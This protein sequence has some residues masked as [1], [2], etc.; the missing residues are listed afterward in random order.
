[1]LSDE[2]AAQDSYDGEQV[3]L[4]PFVREFILLDLPMNVMRTDLPPAPDAAI[5][6]PS[7]SSD[8]SHAAEQPLDPRLAPLAAIASRLRQNKE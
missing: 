8:S 2:L 4:D 5:A 7:E 1:M 3:V 6:P